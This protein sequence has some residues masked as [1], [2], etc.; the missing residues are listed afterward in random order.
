MPSDFAFYYLTQPLGILFQLALL[1]V[2]VL[3]LRAAAPTSFRKV[4]FRR[5][6]QGYG[7][8]ALVTL[9]LAFFE[10]FTLGRSKVALGHIPADTFATWVSSSVLYLFVLMF[11]FTLLFTSFLVAPITIW[12]GSRNRATLPAIVMVGVVVA[13]LVAALSAAFPS[14]EWARAHPFGEFWQVLSSI[15]IGVILVPFGFGLG[16]R[17]PVRQAVGE[18][19]T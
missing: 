6:A 14:N 8:V 4:G 7:G 3:L 17:L 12:F 13:V 11:I 9:C 15:G 16:A 5:I 2:P 10:A 19:A 18:N 1:V